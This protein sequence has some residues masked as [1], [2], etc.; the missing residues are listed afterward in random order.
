[1]DKL[2]KPQLFVWILVLRRGGGDS[3]GFTRPIPGYGSVDQL[4]GVPIIGKL[5]RDGTR[6]P[7]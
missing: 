1:M 7:E 5:P 3:G 6:G 4:F 2:T